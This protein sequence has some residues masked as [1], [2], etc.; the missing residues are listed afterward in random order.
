MS[1]SLLHEAVAA[2]REAGAAIRAL[3]ADR[4]VLKEKSA[5]NPLTEADLAADAIL[6]ARL[7]DRHPDFGWLS[8]E[9]AD[10]ASRLRLSTSWIVDPLDGTKEFTEG[11]PE[12]V[13]SIG[14][15]HGGVP[16]LGVLYNPITGELFTGVVGEG[17]TLDGAPVRVSTHATLA[18]ARVACS[19]TELKRGDL[20]A[21]TELALH[22]IGSVAYKLGLVAAGRVEANFTPNPRNAWDIAGGVA[23][24]L[25]AGGRVTNG[26][27]QEL[28]F[29]RL[30]PL[31]EDGLYAS[32]GAIHTALVARCGSTQA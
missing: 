8:E 7:R 12:F 17:A 5:G 14:L 6:S 10:D 28:R 20:A 31:F 1:P 4:T 22:P 3:Y 2:A 15:V 13:V 25:A 9:T 26:V 18:G 29:D 27:G 32:N 24:V 19:A 30:S 16:V 11:V 23:C 21:F